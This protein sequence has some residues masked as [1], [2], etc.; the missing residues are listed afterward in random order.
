M[1]IAEGGATEGAGVQVAVAGKGEREPH[2]LDS[3]RTFGAVVQA[4]REHAGLSRED[5]GTR[6]RYSK[7]TWNQSS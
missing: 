6:V 7:R 2:P 5:L 3:L 4:L 1:S